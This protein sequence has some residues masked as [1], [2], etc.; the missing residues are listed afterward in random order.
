MS[1]ITI[2][3]QGDILKN[4]K[5]IIHGPTISLIVLF[6]VVSLWIFIEPSGRKPLKI[7]NFKK[8]KKEESNVSID[9]RN[10]NFLDK[11]GK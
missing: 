7:I 9:K 6:T 3:I 2:K 4:R 8:Y 5:G 10:Y 1:N 11:I